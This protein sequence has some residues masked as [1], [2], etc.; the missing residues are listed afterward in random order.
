L[1]VE[2]QHR[3]GAIDYNELLNIVEEPV[4]A[5]PGARC[6]SL[7]SG[8]HTERIAENA[9]YKP[10][11][12]LKRSFDADWSRIAFD[13]PP[14]LDPSQ[15]NALHGLLA[16]LMPNATGTPQIDPIQQA[17]M[18]GNIAASR[19][20]ADTALTHALVSRGLG[21]SGI[22]GPGQ[23]PDNPGLPFHPGAGVPR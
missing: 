12:F 10:V 2:P 16:S 4:R 7:I 15:Q 9:G 8:K 19:T 22:L 20:G 3:G 18:C 21:R 11:A 13:R 14:S 1:W 6:Y 5:V 17:L 23:Q